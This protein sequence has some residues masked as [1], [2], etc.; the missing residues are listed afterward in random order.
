[1]LRYIETAVVSQRVS[2]TQVM[3][4]RL[5]GLK[6]AVPAFEALTMIVPPT[7]TGVA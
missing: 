7:I 4:S 6:A 3:P 5:I 2:V 1:L